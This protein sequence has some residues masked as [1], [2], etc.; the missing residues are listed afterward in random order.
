MRDGDCGGLAQGSGPGS[1]EFE[2]LKLSTN[3]AVHFVCVLQTFN[4]AVLRAKTV[5]DT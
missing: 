1:L 3:D 2:S 5:P 4:C